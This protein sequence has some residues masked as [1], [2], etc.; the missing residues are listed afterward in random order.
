LPI[1]TRNFFHGFVFE[2]S[3]RVKG[4]RPEQAETERPARGNL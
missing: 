1:R 2:L 3:E 4:R